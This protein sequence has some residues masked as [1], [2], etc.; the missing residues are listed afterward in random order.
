T[1]AAAASAGRERVR[2]AGGRRRA[3]LRRGGGRREDRRARRRRRRRR[4]ARAA[5]GGRRHD[6]VHVDKAVVELGTARPVLA[7]LGLI[8]VG[9]RQLE[10][11]AI[12]VAAELIADATRLEVHAA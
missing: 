5:R 3:D 6:T 7:R 12:G 2:R 4:R 10:E 9:A 11:P 8:V 1:Q